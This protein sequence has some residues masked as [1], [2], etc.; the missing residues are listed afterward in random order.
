MMWTLLATAAISGLIGS[1]LRYLD[2]PLEIKK[3]NRNIYCI[4]LIIFNPLC[5][6]FL[7][8]LYLL[9]GSQLSHWLAFNVGISAPILIR[10]AARASTALNVPQK[11]LVEQ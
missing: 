2:D 10:Q 6:L 8:G 4:I 5:G 1:F 11:E 9:D 7:V 3:Y